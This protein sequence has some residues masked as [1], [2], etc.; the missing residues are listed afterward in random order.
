MA[1]YIN[2]KNLNKKNINYISNHYLFHFLYP[3]LILP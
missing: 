2:I 3:L 1:G